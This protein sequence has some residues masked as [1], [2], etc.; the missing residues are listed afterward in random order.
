MLESSS[1]NLGPYLMSSD[2]WCVSSPRHLALSVLAPS[3]QN[4]IGSTPLTYPQPPVHLTGSAKE[5]KGGDQG[6]R[7][8]SGS[9]TS[10]SLLLDGPFASDEVL[11]YCIALGRIGL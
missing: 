11:M 5:A 2:Q 10:K 3:Y 4:A 8:T 1:S 9:D 7:H 6:M